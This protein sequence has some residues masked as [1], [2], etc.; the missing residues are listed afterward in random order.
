MHIA[1]LI[2]DNAFRCE[3]EVI[4]MPSHDLGACSLLSN[5][6]DDQIIAVLATYCC[7][8]KERLIKQELKECV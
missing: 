6:K 1:V 7:N 2:L 4:F 3:R 5:C 8:A